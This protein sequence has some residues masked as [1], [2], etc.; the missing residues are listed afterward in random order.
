MVQY[1]E[2]FG[3]GRGPS[4]LARN[5]DDA[6]RSAIKPKIGHVP[7]VR[8]DIRPQFAHTKVQGQT[9]LTF[10]VIWAILIYEHSPTPPPM[11]HDMR[12]EGDNRSGNRSSHPNRGN[13]SSA[14]ALG[15]HY[16]S[17]HTT[18]SGSASQSMYNTSHD[19]H[20]S[21]SVRHDERYYPGHSNSYQ[22]TTATSGG[23]YYP[24]TSGYYQ[25]D[26]VGYSTADNSHEYG[27]LATS[28]H[29][30]W[31]SSGDPDV[32]VGTGTTEY[33]YVDETEPSRSA[34]PRS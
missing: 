4:L 13:E 1:L 16:Y 2:V 23:D 32:F 27:Y 26:H 21:S 14:L 3:H 22:T 34:G 30:Q 19:Y 15:P 28:D 10:Q 25:S 6:N 9:P 7:I 11:D 8:G 12:L 20:S 18:T 24:V 17:G 29:Q 5:V 33:F 31:L